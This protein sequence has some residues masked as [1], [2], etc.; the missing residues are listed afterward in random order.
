MK[1]TVKVF[2]I[3]TILFSLFL[4]LPQLIFAQYEDILNPVFIKSHWKVIQNDSIVI[5]E[6]TLSN[7]LDTVFI[8]SNEPDSEDH[9]EYHIVS[10]VGS[11][12]SYDFNYAMFGGAHPTS[13]EWYRT[14]NI[15]TKEEVSLENLFSSKTILGLISKDTNFTKYTQNKNP[16]DI[17][18]FISSLGGGCE[19]SFSRLLVSYAIK[20]ID[21][22]SVLIEFGLIHG[23]EAC[24]ECFTKIKVKIPKSAMKYN[25]INN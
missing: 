25:F 24:P 17:H 19:V 7:Q 13:G 1:L 22:D 8:N 9:N 14:I 10:I 20:S 18:D 23:C 6:N 12:L 15:D 16:K 5:I 4:S 2:L 11:L 3:R 21:K